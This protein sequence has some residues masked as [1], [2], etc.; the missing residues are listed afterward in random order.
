MVQETRAGL[1]APTPYVKVGGKD[2][3]N[4]PEEW[5]HRM[6]CRSGKQGRGCP[7]ARR[8]GGA[9][10][11]SLPTG[12]WNTHGWGSRMKGWGLPGPEKVASI[13]SW[14]G[15]WLEMGREV[16]KGWRREGA[17]LPLRGG[18]PGHPLRSPGFYS[19]LC[20]LGDSG[21]ISLAIHLLTCQV[22][23]MTAPPVIINEAVY[24][25]LTAEA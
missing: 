7:W 25:R 19:C 22:E 10:S 24:I 5:G 17:V 9:V 21:S 15:K 3:R 8:N 14:S 11:G 2:L 4:H 13:T 20:Q 16:Q 6:E 12:S 1:G 23:T 18:K